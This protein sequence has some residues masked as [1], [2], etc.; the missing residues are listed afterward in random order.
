MS[1]RAAAAERADASGPALVEGLEALGWSVE[2]REVVADDR[3]AIAGL[4]RAWCDEVGLDLVVTTGGTGIAPR[5]VTPEATRDVAD[6][7]APGIAEALRAAALEITP[8]GMLSRAIAATRG[9]TLVVN[10]PGSP[11]AVIEGL[12]VL[13]P[14]LDHAVELLAGG[15]V[16]DHSHRVESP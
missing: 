1:D 4:L 2:R 9:E 5:D 11:K 14:V 12:E 16:D 6:R 13:A 8:H 15:A 3:E 10:L 7:E